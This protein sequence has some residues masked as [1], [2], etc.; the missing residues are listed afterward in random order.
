MRV[1]ALLL[2]T[3]ATA[4]ALGASGAVPGTGSYGCGG[5]PEGVSCRSAREVYRLT[6]GGKPVVALPGQ[7][8]ALDQAQTSLEAFPAQPSGWRTRSIAAAPPGPMGSQVQVLAL[9]PED[10]GAPA[11]VPLRTPSRVLRVWIAPWEDERH[12]LHVPG[13][14]FAEIEPRRWSIGQGQPQSRRLQPL[15]EVPAPSD[16]P[17]VE[18]AGA[19]PGSDPSRAASPPRRPIRSGI[20]DAGADD[21]TF[22][23]PP[24]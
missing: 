14:T 6:D 11:V 19:G 20:E 17:P 21:T 8:T 4:A 5:L 16:G 2:L 15:P 7:P 10:A 1:T 22:Q 23:V 18:A 9:R 24:R 13:F 3:V 12:R